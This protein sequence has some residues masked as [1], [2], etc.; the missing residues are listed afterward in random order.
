MKT[1]EDF[2][3]STVFSYACCF[4]G[5]FKTIFRQFSIYL[6]YKIKTRRN[7]EENCLREN[8][9]CRFQPT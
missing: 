2:L 6:E 8:Y 9:K 5:D 1:F 4:K 3:F 7:Q